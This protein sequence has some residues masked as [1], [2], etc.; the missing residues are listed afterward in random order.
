MRF[1]IDQGHQADVEGEVVGAGPEHHVPEHAA[2]VDVLE[3]PP[4]DLTAHGLPLGIRS[5]GPGVGLSVDL[6]VNQHGL[7]TA[8]PAGW[9]TEAEV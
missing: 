7:V 2:G 1:G 5:H 6:T 3:D 4:P 8:Y 9:M